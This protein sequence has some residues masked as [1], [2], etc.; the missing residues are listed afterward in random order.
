MGIDG[1]KSSR[2]LSGQTVSVEPG[3]NPADLKAQAHGREAPLV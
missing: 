2:R 3:D 1:A